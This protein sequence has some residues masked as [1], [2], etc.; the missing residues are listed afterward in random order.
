MGKTTSLDAI[1]DQFQSNLGIGQSLLLGFVISIS[2]SAVI[3][4]L[5]LIAIHLNIE[6]GFLAAILFSTGCAVVE[7]IFVR[8]ITLLTRWLSTKKNALWYMEW[9][10]LVLFLGLTAFW[11][12]AAFAQT[13]NPS[14][15]ISYFFAIPTFLLGIVIRFLYPSMIPFWLAWNTILVTRKLHFKIIPFVLGVGL[16]TIMMHA[17]Y[18]FAGHIMMDFIKHQGQLM[19]GLIGAIFFVTTILQVKRIVYFSSN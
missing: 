2:G 6:K 5:H 10:L 11:M 8:Y 1:L 19:M 13:E 12:Y 9:V 15:S 16:A 4:A 7:I 3:G 17:A 18:I 14:S